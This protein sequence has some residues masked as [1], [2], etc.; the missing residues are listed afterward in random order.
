MYW[1]YDY[2][3]KYTGIQVGSPSL[4]GSMWEKTL[5]WDWMKFC[6]YLVSLN[7]IITHRE[8]RTSK[9]ISTNKMISIRHI[10]IIILFRNNVVKAELCFII[11]THVLF[12]VFSVR[13]IDILYFYSVYIVSIYFIA[14]E[15]LWKILI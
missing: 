15:I 10:K 6:R 7:S 2:N 12:L 11:Y 13:P 5:K 14:N 8:H 1:T 9:F 4:S 3:Y